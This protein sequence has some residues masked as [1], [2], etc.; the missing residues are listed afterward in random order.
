[1]RKRQ[2]IRKFVSVVLA[3]SMTAMLAGCGNGK[4][5]AKGTH[6]SQTS[7]EKSTEMVS[8][9]SKN[10]EG[11]TAKGE[12]NSRKAGD[13]KMVA[14]DNLS[15]EDKGGIYYVFQFMDGASTGWP[16]IKYVD[17]KAG[18]EVFLCNK[19]NCNHGDF[20]CTA[21]L[22]KEIREGVDNFILFGD[23]DY[24]YL[25]MQLP[26]SN[27]GME[28]SEYSEPEW[29][30]ISGEDDSKINYPPTIYR[31]KKDGT[32][33]EKI[34]EFDS[35]ISVEPYVFSDGKYLYFNT[36]TTKE[37]TEG[38]TTYFSCY[39]RQIVRLDLKE[40]SLE[41]VLDLNSW[42][43]IEGCY[44]RD[45]ILRETQF[46]REISPEFK[47]TNEEEYD[48][49]YQKAKT[50]YSLHNIDSGKATTIK[51]IENKKDH[52]TCLANGYL[53]VACENKKEIEKI[54]LKGGKVKKIKTNRVF[55]YL[56]GYVS[57]K[58]KPDTLICGCEEDDGLYYLN[59]KTGE[60][61]K[62]TL[63]NQYDEPI[64]V[65]SENDKYL[66]VENDCKKDQIYPKDSEQSDH[67]AEYEYS[68]ISK[69][70]YLN[71]KPNYKSVKMIY[72]GETSDLPFKW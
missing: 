1:M 47:Y 52:K 25:L 5:G 55:L 70:D 43:K 44:G 4:D 9:E 22:P 37:T 33:R 39:D 69:E 45:I 61:V 53:Y 71:N 66:F 19:L 27:D 3:V 8:Q 18:K 36:I 29:N 46:D 26:Y 30:S 15:Y 28:I 59:S 10:T 65:I 42:Q 21:I 54:H 12:T 14:D 35:G 58:D 7:T 20:N 31:M 17:Y 72:S 13:L 41:K 64:I 50:V 62:S 6:A 60:Y 57:V 63:V 16:I 38:N 32:G 40:K 34:Y 2:F 48:Q 11:N 67:V 49:L 23:E 68:V 56:N 51:T 24:L